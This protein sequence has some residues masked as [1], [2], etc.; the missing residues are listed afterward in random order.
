MTLAPFSPG[1][2][3][4]TPLSMVVRPKGVS[5]GPRQMLSSW[6]T[7][8]PPQGVMSVVSATAIAG[9]SAPQP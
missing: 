3:S 1:L 8:K 9:I 7:S 2:L 4:P 5:K 6:V